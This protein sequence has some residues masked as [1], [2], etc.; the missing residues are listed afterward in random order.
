MPHLLEVK[1]LEVKFALR[2]GDLTAING[3]NFTLDKGERLGIVGES[4]AG[5]STIG[6]SAMGYGRGSIRLSGQVFLNG[7]DILQ[8]GIRGLRRLR[9][10]EVTYVSQSA[11][12]SFNPAKK[13]MEQ[14]V[15]AA[16]EHGVASKT[17]AEKRA[18]QLFR[19]LS[20]PNPDTIGNRYPHQVSGGQLQRAMTVMALVPE[21]DLIIFDEPTTALDVTTQIDVLSAIKKAIRNTGVAALYI[22]HDLAVVAQVS[23]EIMVLRN[24]EKVERN[25][26]ENIINNP[27][28][29]YTKRLI[30]ATP[31][32]DLGHIKALRAERQRK[33]QQRVEGATA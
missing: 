20:L 30:D 33:R 1:D 22:T 11:A 31:K 10:K 8:V 19:E 29:D 28:E 15:E 32:D 21:P 7:R 25:S 5:K 2:F 18:V 4:G 13:L 17:E 27:Q 16:L 26:A 14:I 3:V 23:D 12:A 6:L 24:G 9:G